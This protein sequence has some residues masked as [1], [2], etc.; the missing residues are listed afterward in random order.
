MGEVGS[1]Y[2]YTQISVQAQ[3]T[4]TEGTLR[5]EIAGGT[6]L[7]WKMPKKKKIN[8]TFAFTIFA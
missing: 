6:S 8:D 4:R 3:H 5:E 2:K 7:R 1:H